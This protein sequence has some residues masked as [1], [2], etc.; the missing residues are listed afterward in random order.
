MIYA[1]EMVATQCLK[2]I[3][4]FFPPG[5]GTVGQWWAVSA[6]RVSVPSQDI[7]ISSNHGAYILGREVIIIS[8]VSYVHV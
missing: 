4:P 7:L 3:Y 6:S 5:M 2:L 1:W 8:R